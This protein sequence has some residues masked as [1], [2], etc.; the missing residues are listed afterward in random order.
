MK[1][2][3]P[4]TIYSGDLNP[5][6]ETESKIPI[7]LLDKNQE[8]EIICH[9]KLG[10][11]VEHIKYSPGLIFYKNNIDSD[12]LDYVHIEDGKVTYDEEELKNKNL[13]EEQINKVKSVK[14]VPELEFNIESW[15]QIE[16]RD[17]F[18]RS[19][20]VLEENLKVLNKAIK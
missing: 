5:S 6:V 11:G 17:I 10:E 15:G 16:V 2:V 12:V 9:A 14:E 3:G 19:I 20:D 18:L 8:V 13:S 7:V 4:K 1:E